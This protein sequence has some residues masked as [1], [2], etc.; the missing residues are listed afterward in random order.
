M[1]SSPRFV[2]GLKRTLVAGGLIV[3]LASAL[4]CGVVSAPPP[5]TAPERPD[6]GPGGRRQP[7]SMSPRQELA[8]GR[9]AYRQIVD[10]YGDRLLPDDHPQVRRVRNI[11]GRLRQAAEIKPLQREILLRVR[12]YVFEWEANVIREGQVNA[13]CLPAGKIFVFTGILPVAEDDDQL[14]AVLSHEMAHA[15]A[16]HASERVAREQ[17]GAGVLRSLS[18]NRMQESEADHIGVFLMA[19]A[20]FDPDAAVTFWRRMQKYQANRGRPPEILS[21]HPSDERRIHDLRAWAPKAREARRA[22]DEGRV[23]PASR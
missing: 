17:S 5:R 7:L 8:V 3:A 19:F 23:A 9:R 1:A 10:E 2:E 6:A 22:Y 20:D 4:A 14:A 13:F 15:L 12:D 18:Y 21:D 11:T 16:H